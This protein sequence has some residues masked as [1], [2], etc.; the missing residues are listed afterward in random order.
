MR[1]LVSYGR[2]ELPFPDYAAKH[3]EVDL[4]VFEIP[5]VPGYPASAVHKSVARSLMS[6]SVAGS[7]I[8]AVYAVPIVLLN[9]Y[10]V[11][12]LF[13][14]YL[15]RGR[16]PIL[17]DHP[18]ALTPENLSALTSD[19][20]AAQNPDSAGTQAPGATAVTFRQIPASASANSGQREIVDTHEFDTSA[21]PQEPR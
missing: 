13:V 21:E 12:G 9:L 7:L 6:K 8:T 20:L 2:L 3:P 5:Q 15:V 10:V 4:D 17:P 16:Y 11:G 18:L 1:A 19:T 14:D